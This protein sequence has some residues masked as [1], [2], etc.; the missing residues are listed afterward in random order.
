MTEIDFRDIYIRANATSHEWL[1]IAYYDTCACGT[2]FS[3][4]LYNFGEDGIQIN[5]FAYFNVFLFKAVKDIQ[6]V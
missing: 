2:N 1:L 6:K 3:S 5:F 4:Y